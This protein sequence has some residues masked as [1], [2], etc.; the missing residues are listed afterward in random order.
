MTEK[1]QNKEK[2]IKTDKVD[3]KNKITDLKSEK[4]IQSKDINSDQKSEKNSKKVKS[5][6]QQVQEHY[7]RYTINLLS[8]RGVNLK[9]IGDLVMSLQKPYIKNLNKE[10]IYNAII[11]VLSKRETQNAVMTGIE[12]DVKAEKRELSEPLQS[13]ME[14][15]EPLYGIDEVL[16]DSITEI[17]GSIGKTNYGYLDKL[18]PGILQ[19]LNDR[20]TGF[21]NVFLDDLVGAIAASAAALL[22]HNEIE[23]EDGNSVYLEGKQLP[24]LDKDFKPAEIARRAVKGREMPT[25]DTFMYGKTK[26]F[27]NSQNVSKRELIKFLDKNDFPKDHEPFVAMKNYTL[28]HIFVY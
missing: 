13:I 7:L 8:S 17:Y 25:P 26:I 11:K 12:L 28:K 2:I 20:T 16:T 21:V 1:S 3:K 5:K 4:K 23:E 14:R 18:K 27:Y 22:A 19:W 10:K 15:D 6:K 24:D 9:D